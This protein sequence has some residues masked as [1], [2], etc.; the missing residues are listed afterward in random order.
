MKRRLITLAGIAAVIGAAIFWFLTAPSYLDEARVAEIVA[1]YQEAIVDA[2]DSRCRIALRAGRYKALAIGG[3]VSLNSR[4]RERLI[5]TAEDV[6][7]RILLAEPR[8]CGDN[9]AMIAGL[10]GAGGG[11]CGPEAFKL[12]VVP[13][14]VT[15]RCG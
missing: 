10:A 15:G 9:A 11:V 13:S 8:F 1:A 12:D 3:G 14:L 4:L 2:L 5:Q 7:V 6:G